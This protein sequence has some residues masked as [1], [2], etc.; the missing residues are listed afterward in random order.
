MYSECFSAIDLHLLGTTDKKRC[1]FIEQYTENM[2]TDII[3]I[4]KLCTYDCFVTYIYIYGRLY[5]KDWI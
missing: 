4:I 3:I 1:S 2:T 5:F